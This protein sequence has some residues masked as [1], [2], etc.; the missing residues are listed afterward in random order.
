MMEYQKIFVSMICYITPLSVV[1]YVLLFHTLPTKVSAAN[2]YVN[3]V[4]PVIVEKSKLSYGNSANWKY[5]RKKIFEVQGDRC[6]CCGKKSEHLHVD[7]IKPKSRYPHL[8]FMIDNLQVLCPECNMKKSNSHE[9]DYRKTEHL[10]SLVREINNNKLLQRK[11]VYD[12][13]VLEK[14]ANK[15]FKAEMKNQSYM[16]ILPLV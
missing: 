16:Q 11:Y 14:L 7:H 15:R 10:V 9:T 2:Y 4:A 12:F 13:K 5:L 8:E 6:L 1:L 3:F